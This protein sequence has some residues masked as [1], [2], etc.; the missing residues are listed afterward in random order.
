[1]MDAHMRR[2]RSTKTTVWRRLE[3]C[4]NVY[5]IHLERLA[6]AVEVEPS[7]ELVL[8]DPQEYA[9]DSAARILRMQWR[10]PMGP[11]RGLTGWLEA[12]GCSIV[13]DDFNA[14]GGA[15]RIDGL[16]QWTIQSPVK[17]ILINRNAPIDRVR[18]TLAHEL[19]HICLHHEHLE[20]DPEDEADSFAAEF[21]MPSAE[22][23]PSLHNLTIPNLHNLKRYWG[24]SMQAI[25]QHAY[26]LGT[27]SRDQRTH[28]FKI[29]SRNGWRKR[30]PLS[31]ELPPEQPQLVK[32]LGQVLLDRGLTVEEVATIAGVSPNH[33]AFFLS[34]PRL[35]AL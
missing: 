23:R 34:R 32:R 2:R 35:R 4:L 11:I 19:G 25:I 27:I 10:M 21:L 30:E 3:A 18:W 29:F 12:A 17:I 7:R 8:F 20:A 5:R 15:G 31:D 14:I 26:R 33:D 1:M 28:L 9:P 13:T 6:K 22:I 16:S 24:V